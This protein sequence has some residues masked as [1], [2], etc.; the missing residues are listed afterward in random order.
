MTDFVTRWMISAATPPTHVWG[1]LV[2]ALC[3]IGLLAISI[4]VFTLRNRLH[5]KYRDDEMERRG[6]TVLLGMWWRH[7]FAWLM[8]APLRLVRATGIPP[9]VVTLLSVQLAVGS[10]VAVAA[11]HLALGGWLFVAAGACDFLDGRLA[12]TTGTASPAGAVL[13]SVVDRYVEGAAYIGLAWLFRDSWVLLAVLLALF[14]SMMVPYVRARGE[15][16]GVRMA[17][18]GIVQRPERIVVIALVLCASPIVEALWTAPQAWP[19]HPVVALG[20]MFLAVSTQV[21]AVQR[22]VH[23]WSKLATPPAAPVVRFHGRGSVTRNVIA[24]SS[25]T[26]IDFAAVLLMV[27]VLEISPPIATLVGC[28]VGASFNFMTNRMWT[29]GSDGHPAVQVGRYALVSMGSAVLNG[30]LVALALLLPSVPSLLA[31][32]A[33][34]ALV[35]VTW[36]YP[37]HRD[38][39]FGPSAAQW[40]PAE[41]P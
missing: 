39:V 21:S 17:E 28:G 23:A 9:S 15:A 7:Y 38:Y 33:V 24:A 6:A 12:R 25:A 18:V 30:G 29:F 11:G 4:L 8:V 2:P 22:L 3:L 31:W 34:R 10:A 36:N 37:L 1:A 27:Q 40:H 20:M 5:G 35:F 26:I 14:G 19:K 13:D 32:A 16:L 41:A